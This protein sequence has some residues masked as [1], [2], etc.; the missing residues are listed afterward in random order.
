MD[1][2]MLGEPATERSAGEAVPL[3]LPSVKLPGPM[4]RSAIARSMTAVA[5][6]ARQRMSSAQP[7]I[8]RVQQSI[9]AFK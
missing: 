2:A 6:W 4:P 7:T 8:S 3:S 5:S 9:A 1:D